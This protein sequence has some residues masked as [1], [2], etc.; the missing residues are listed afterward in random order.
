MSDALLH[1]KVLPDGRIVEVWRM[2]FNLRI[3]VSEPQNDG[4]CWEDAWCY[5]APA[6]CIAAFHAWDGEGEPVGWI[7][8]P[9]S[10]RRRESAA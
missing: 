5:N 9:L 4:I 6:V 7:K 2:L 3:T 1:R 8:H 10:G